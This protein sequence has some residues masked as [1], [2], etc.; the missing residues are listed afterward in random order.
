MIVD[1]ASSTAISVDTF[2]S[3]ASFGEWAF[4][5]AIL[6]SDLT[7][8]SDSTSDFTLSIANGVLLVGDYN[9]ASLSITQNGLSA[10]FYSIENPYTGE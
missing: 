6:C 4:T 7:V 3:A 1:L 2:L 10:E 5:T 9:S 8:F